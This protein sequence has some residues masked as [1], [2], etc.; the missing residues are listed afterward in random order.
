MGGVDGWRGVSRPA[1]TYPLPTQKQPID[2]NVTDRSNPFPK[3][4]NIHT[5]AGLSVAKM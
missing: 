4:K 3:R 5:D 1:S 2:Q